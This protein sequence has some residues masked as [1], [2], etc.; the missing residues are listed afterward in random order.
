MSHTSVSVSAPRGCQGGRGNSQGLQQPAPSGATIAGGYIPVTTQELCCV[1]G[2]LR[3]GL[4]RP[5]DVRTWLAAHEVAARRKFAPRDS[6][7]VYEPEELAR[8]VGSGGGEPGVRASLR[9]LGALGL[10]TW[11][12]GGPRFIAS[13]EDIQTDQIPEGVRDMLA[14]MPRGR[15]TFPMPRR[16]LRLLAGGVTRAVLATVLGHLVRCVHHDARS[17]WSG[18]GATKAS[19]VAEAFG[20]SERS[21]VRARAHLIEELRW[22]EPLEAPQ[23]YQNA[24]GGRFRVDLAW[25]GEAALP[26]PEAAPGDARLSPPL[27][28]FDAGLSPPRE[29]QISPSE[30]Q[31]SDLGGEAPAPPRTD[32]F[33]PKKGEGSKALPPPRLGD[34]TCADLRHIPRVME[35]FDQALSSPVWRS[36]G[37]TPQDTPAE[38]L[39]W[40]GAARRASVRGGPNPPGLFV[41][42]VTRRLWGHVTGDDE[43]AVRVAYARWLNPEPPNEPARRGGG[44][45]TL[46]APSRRALG[47]DASVIRRVEAVL[48]ERA[49]L[50]T[51]AEVDRELG[52]AGWSPERIAAARAELRAA[53]AAE[54]E[55]EE[56]TLTQGGTFR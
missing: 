26:G 6:R 45:L 20:L 37:W 51:R 47:P 12:A 10:V 55:A 22:L 25:G 19:W 14:L 9:R 44:G 50:T 27:A 39:N 4:I 32:V 40:A 54:V 36:R 48:R 13:V 31:E 49:P 8:L 46:F 23:W 3:D 38:R 11:T 33:E 2:S 52:R 21:V 42:L 17:G 35:L 29:E 1:W 28:P 18:E 56:D 5:L 7:P 34:V 15:R 16:V 30:I 53:R 41:H 43:D 24:Y